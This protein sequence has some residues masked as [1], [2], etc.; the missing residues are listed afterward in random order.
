MRGV[1]YARY[2]EG[3]RQTDQSIEG[4]V[5]DCRAYAAEHGIDIIGI[6]AD[7]HISGTSTEGR[8]DFLR[9]IHDAERRLFDA[10]IVW[11][12]DRFGRSREDIAV[13]KIRLRKAGVQLMYAKEAVPDGP[14]GILLESLLEGL[15]EYYSA[16]LRQKVTRGIRETAKK[17]LSPFGTLPIGYKTDADRR[18]VVDPAKAEAVR[19]VFRMQLAGASTAAMQEALF[20]RGV[21]NKGKKYGK[22]TIHRILR[23]EHYL[24]SFFVQGVEIKVEPIIDKETFEAAA[25]SFRGPYQNAAGRADVEYLLS[26]KCHC[27]T[28]GKM[29]QGTHGT[30]KAGQKYYYYKCPTKGCLKPV[31]KDQ[32][33]DLVLQ[34]TI[35]DV[36][37]D[38]MIEK[39]TRRIMEVQE[40]EHAG[41]PAEALKAELKAAKKRQHNL[42]DAIEN[43]AG[44]SI[45]ARLN[46]VEAQIDGLTHEIE[47]ATLQHPVIPETMVRG[48]LQSFRGGDVTDPVFRRKLV[49]TFVADV[50]VGPELVTVAYNTTQKEP[51]ACSRTALSP[52]TPDP[53]SNT[54][55]VLPDYIIFAFPRNKKEGPAKGP[56]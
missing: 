56:V 21:T 19:E 54:P 29:L 22:G 48:W 49:S 45:V 43:G 53:Y 5:A 33:E 15:A 24:G 39:L 41:D 34:H 27:A 20:R 1:I 32:L 35:E 42:I 11:K 10:V 12:V 51:H 13:N 31:P 2:S 44:A 6:Y 8:D 26:C 25:A 17:G 7:R 36:L 46:E 52:Q 28:C 50:V 18:I 23:N 38:D 37:T 30:G 4:Q 3:P 9:M 16:D 55:A 47:R 40:A 14:E